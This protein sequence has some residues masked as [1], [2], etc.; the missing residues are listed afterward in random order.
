MA[1][2]FYNPNPNKLIVG[3]CVIRAVSRLLEEDWDA[4]YARISLQGFVMKDMPSS[5]GVWGQCLLD[6]KFEPVMSI[7]QYRNP[8]C[9]VRSFVEDH[10]TGRFLLFIGGHV[11]TVV[12]GDYYDTWD[13]GDEVPLFYW[14]E[15]R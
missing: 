7:C 15:K 6:N 12:N 9:T 14:K 4:T 2:R 8:P 11:V 1:F 13:S 5:N 3:D 10:P